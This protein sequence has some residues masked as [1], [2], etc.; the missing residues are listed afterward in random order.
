MP[1]LSFTGIAHPAPGRDRKHYADL[2]G[3]EIGTTQ[4]GN[5][6]GTDILVEH[7]PGTRVGTVHASWESSLTK[8][9]HV[10]GTV[11]DPATAA[12]VRQG[13]LRGLSLGTGVDHYDGHVVWRQ[14][15]ELSLCE[16]PRRAGCFIDS[17]DGKSVRAK[18]NFS[19]GSRES[20]PLTSHKACT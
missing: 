6:G 3:A 15:D 12:R 13:T 7:E 5:R 19:N 20:P 11:D 9:M 1:A 17:I 2:N 14:Q 18:H 10:V 4:M 8:G 16:Q